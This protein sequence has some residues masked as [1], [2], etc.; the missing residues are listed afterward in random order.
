M[1]SINETRNFWNKKPELKLVNFVSW[2]PKLIN[3]SRSASPN[4]NQ[5]DKANLVLYLFAQ[6]HRISP[7]FTI[8]Q[9]SP[10]SHVPSNTYPNS[11]SLSHKGT[12]STFI[13]TTPLLSILIPDGLARITNER[14]NPNP[15]PRPSPNPTPTP[16]QP[17]HV[18]VI[19]LTPNPNPNSNPP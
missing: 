9:I 11:L 7:I 19:E 18:S 14:L 5:A 3:L 4:R 13:S 12:L 10:T 1:V 2:T 17:H 16:N 15:N 6:G 8:P